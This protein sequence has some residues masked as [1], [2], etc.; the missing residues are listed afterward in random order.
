MIF[1]PFEFRPLPD[2]DTGRVQNLQKAYQGIKQGVNVVEAMEK[3]LVKD[4]YPKSGDNVPLDEDNDVLMVLSRNEVEKQKAD[5]EMA[6][7]DKKILKKELAK[8]LEIIDQKKSK[9]ILQNTVP[10][11]ERKVG[12]DIDLLLAMAFMVGILLIG[13]LVAIFQIDRTQ[14]NL[15]F[16]QQNGKLQKVENDDLKWKIELMT[17]DMG[18]M[19][20]T[21][22]MAKT[23]LDESI[24][25]KDDYRNAKLHHASINGQF[26][27]AEILIKLGADVNSRDHLQRTP[28]H[29]AALE[30]QVGI[31]RLLLQNGANVNETHFLQN[32]PLHFASLN[33]H[34]EIAELFLK[35][36]AN[37]NVKNSR[38]MT[39][40]HFAARKGHYVCV[41]FLL[42][43]GADI[44]GIDIH[45]FTPLH[46]AAM[47]GFLET[48]KL[49][50]ENGADVNA[51][52]D[53]QDTPLHFAVNYGY[54]E[55]SKL[56]IQNGA[57]VNAKGHDQSTP[58]HL[59]AS[60]NN[61]ETAKLLLQ[62]GADLDVMDKHKD[63]PLH[64]AAIDGQVGVVE[65]LL[66]YGA[67]KD[68]K[69]DDNRTPLQEAEKWIQLETWKDGEFSKVITL[70]KQN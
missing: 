49:L 64:D 2:I 15:E 58:L 30:G 68:L 59:A 38:E 55:I 56:L 19:E 46:I 41:R 27:D 16:C 36:G 29:L 70:L 26:E 21:I 24:N 45:Q 63:T 61:V 65:V 54:L 37:V 17:Q 9:L 47:E 69:N 40:L 20:K 7:N 67:R 52:K 6:Q 18:G 34:F 5:L 44:N 42:K 22:S 39:P 13:L 48:S 28:L 25:A 51:K 23:L 33:G 66:K 10:K 62:N 35:N 43:N 32:T 3:D 50:I 11:K 14:S 53:N 8:A 1:P 31:T 12:L 57:D 60:R 4:S